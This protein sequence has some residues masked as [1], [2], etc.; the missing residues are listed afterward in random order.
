MFGKSVPLLSPSYYS[1][2]LYPI[3]EVCAMR[4]AQLIP[5]Y[6]ADV[7][8]QFIFATQMQMIS[9]LKLRLAKQG[10]IVSC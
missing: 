3:R 8:N 4:D 2:S 10:I 6:L 9:K 1:V 7:R 5:K